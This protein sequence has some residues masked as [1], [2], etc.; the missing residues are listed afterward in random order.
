MEKYK[1]LKLEEE[2]LN[3]LYGLV[4][5]CGAGISYRQM[6]P[7]VRAKLKN[8]IQAMYICMIRIDAMEAIDERV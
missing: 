1:E 2:T 6:T 7:D 3:R 5:C 4:K 8:Q